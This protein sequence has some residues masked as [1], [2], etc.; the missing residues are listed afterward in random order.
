MF[1]APVLEIAIVMLGFII[2]MMEAFAETM[3]RRTLAL[4]SIF[5]LAAVLAGSFF[6]SPAPP[7]TATGFWSFY[8]ADALAIFFKRFALVTTIIVLVMMIDY[9]PIVRE[10]VHGTTHQSGLGEFFALP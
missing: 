1:S 10:S 8:S 5:G 3:D 2:L 4:V 9:A 7:A 6:L